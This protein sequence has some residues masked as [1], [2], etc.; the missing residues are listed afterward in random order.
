MKFD[1]LNNFLGPQNYSMSKSLALLKLLGVLSLSLAWPEFGAVCRTG[2]IM[3][4]YLWINY[5]LIAPTLLIIYLKTRIQTYRK[6]V[7]EEANVFVYNLFKTNWKT[8]INII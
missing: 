3:K 1:E 6:L 7:K 4:K 8:F 2:W 5:L